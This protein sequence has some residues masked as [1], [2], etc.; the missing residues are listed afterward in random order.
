MTYVIC[1]HE[2][3][4]EISNT[5]WCPILNIYIAQYGAMIFVII[6]MDIRAL[7]IWK[8]DRVTRLSELVEKGKISKA[9]TH[10]SLH[11]IQFS[12]RLTG[13]LASI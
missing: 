1:D 5:L 12:T 3:L 13:Q 8:R 9:Y 7:I 2:P 11:Y 4:L 10:Y 6:Y